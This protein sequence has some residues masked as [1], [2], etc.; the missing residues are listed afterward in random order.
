M[1]MNRASLSPSPKPTALCV[2][3]LNPP[4]GRQ[5]QGEV[6]FMSEMMMIL[7]LHIIFNNEISNHPSRAYIGWN[8]QA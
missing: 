8:H 2:M 6:F 1:S 4:P 3:L 5:G 7:F